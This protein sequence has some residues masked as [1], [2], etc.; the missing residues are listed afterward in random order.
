MYNLVMKMQKQESHYFKNHGF[1]LV[2]SPRNSPEKPPFNDPHLHRLH[3]TSQHSF[4][5]IRV[6][7]HQV[8]SIHLYDLN[9]WLHILQFLRQK[10]RQSQ[11]H[12]KF[13]LNIQ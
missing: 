10:Q 9:D 7:L 13:F 11:E 1:K 5:F 12:Q 4:D 2:R 3:L 6:V 8:L